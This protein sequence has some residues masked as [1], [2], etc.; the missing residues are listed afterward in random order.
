MTDGN[1]E[2]SNLTGFDD[3]PPRL[4]DGDASE[5]PHIAHPRGPLDVIGERLDRIEAQAADVV[6]VTQVLMQIRH[7]LDEVRSVVHHLSQQRAM[8]EVQMELQVRSIA[9]DQAIKTVPEAARV[10]SEAG[11]II[12]GLADAYVSWLKVRAQ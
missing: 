6:K 2:A 3:K 8:A 11:D 5:P 7:D 4:I 12:T 9:L 1:G 10:S